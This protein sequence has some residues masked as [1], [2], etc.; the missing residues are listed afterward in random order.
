MTTAIRPELAVDV[1]IEELRAGAYRL[2]RGA[3]GT[4]VVTSYSCSMCDRPVL[5]GER[6]VVVTTFPFL[7]LP[8][9][10]HLY[11]VPAARPASRAVPG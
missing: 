8:D 5:L 9:I 11:H 4:S 3:T 1:S 7:G 2:R 6:F 10:A